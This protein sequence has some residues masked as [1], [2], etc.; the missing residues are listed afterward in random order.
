MNAKVIILFLLV[1]ISLVGWVVYAFQSAATRQTTMAEVNRAFPPE[2]YRLFLKAEKLTLYA[3]KPESTNTD[4]EKF[5]GY[6]V[7]G[8]T[9]IAE[10][11]HQKEL[12]G[13]FIR[14]M[15]GAKG[16]ACF[17]PRH[18]LRVETEG[19]TIEIVICFE[20][21]NFAVHFGDEKGKGAVNAQ[22]LES[23]FNQ[24]LQNAGI[25]VAQ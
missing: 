23:P 22:Y 3:L 9:E 17:N 13:A 8:K 6:E 10:V 24:I 21:G 19:K 11:K 16:A 12:K 7:A 18:G 25:S 5:Q 14:E 4:A 1:G 15:A 2:S 20:C